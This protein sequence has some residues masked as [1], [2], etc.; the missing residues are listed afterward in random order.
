[1]NSG[2]FNERMSKMGEDLSHIQSDIAAYSARADVERGNARAVA[3]DSAQLKQFAV[4]Y[5]PNGA[6]PLPIALFRSTVAGPLGRPV[7][8]AGLLDSDETHGE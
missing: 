3:G 5:S 6:K 2:E 8:V 4:D 7:E 1:M